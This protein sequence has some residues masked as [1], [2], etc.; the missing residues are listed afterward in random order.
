MSIRHIIKDVLHPTLLGL[1]EA[2]EARRVGAALPTWAA[3]TEADLKR[4]YDNLVVIEVVDEVGGGDAYVY[5]H[6]GAKFVE[7]F[8]KDLTGFTLDGLPEDQKALIT[9]EYEYARSRRRPTWRVYSGDFD[10]EIITWQRLILPV[11]SDGETIDL[12]LVG[13]YQVKKG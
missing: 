8:G 13:A 5:R 10:G 3:I 7:L 1:Y 11:S 4:W 12:L 9:F 6:Y 2:W